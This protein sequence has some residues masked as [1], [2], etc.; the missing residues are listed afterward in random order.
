MPN[1]AALVEDIQTLPDQTVLSKWKDF[2]RIPYYWE[3]FCVNPNIVVDLLRLVARNL[4]FE[5]FETIYSDIKQNFGAFHAQVETNSQRFRLILVQLI[6]SKYIHFSPF[7]QYLT[8]HDQLKL[9]QGVV[10]VTDQ[11]CRNVFH[12]AAIWS[13]HS[14]FFDLMN[15]LKDDRGALTHLDQCD[16]YG[17][18]P[19][20]YFSL[21]RKD[22]ESIA[23]VMQLLSS[24]GI[25]FAKQHFFKK[26]CPI[27]QPGVNHSCFDVLSEARQKV[28]FKCLLADYFFV[29]DSRDSHIDY[30]SIIDEIKL[31]NLSTVIQQLPALVKQHNLVEGRLRALL[32][33][34]GQSKTSH[35][36]DASTQEKQKWYNLFSRFDRSSLESPSMGCELINMRKDPEDPNSVVS[37]PS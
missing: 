31:D 33:V 12:L 36:N 21:Q 18:T 23:A 25:E 35:S 27:D 9:I 11:S 10:G 26:I 7:I 3:Q 5:V 14:G 6:K 19:L 2:L 29:S 20:Y 8:S 28:F 24:I 34:L 17:K 15:A 37:F 4:S 32:E 1:L 13:P 16:A 22:D 30:Q